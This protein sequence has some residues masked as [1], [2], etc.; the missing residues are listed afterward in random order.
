MMKG[1]VGNGVKI[2]LASATK[3][4]P[5]PGQQ[6]NRKKKQQTRERPNFGLGKAVIFDVIHGDITLYGL[7]T[8]VLRL[9]EFQRTRHV[10]QLGMTQVQFPTGTHSRFVHGIGAAWLCQEWLRL[11][12]PK[13]LEP[14]GSVTNSSDESSEDYEEPG[15]P[16]TTSEDQDEEDDDDEDDNDDGETPPPLN[17]EWV[18]PL[19]ITAR[20][21]ELIVTAALCHDIGHLA[22]SHM[23]DYLNTPFKHEAFGC[24]LIDRMVSRHRLCIST[25]EVKFIHSLIRGNPN[26][27][28]LCEPWMASL[29]SGPLDVDRFDYI[30]RDLVM[31][32]VLSHNNK[33]LDC[34]PRLMRAARVCPT[35]R[36]LRFPRS[37]IPDIRRVIQLRQRVHT[38]IQQSPC[39]QGMNLLMLKYMEDNKARVDRL[40]HED[41][42]DDVLWTWVRED[43]SS[44]LAKA[45]RDGPEDWKGRQAIILLDVILKGGFDQILEIGKFEGKQSLMPDVVQ[46]TTLGALV[47]LEFQ[48]DILRMKTRYASREQR[49]QPEGPT[50][51]PQDPPTVIHV[52]KPKRA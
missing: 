12:F 51:G 38:I 19:G 41:L 46:K 26:E 16:L 24:L 25:A 49:R 30:Q 1:G 10:S 17:G 32:G 47:P 18:G 9:P 5:G 3:R 29:I 36:T 21:R 31:T 52:P 8:R 33:L 42:V 44:R 7:P 13:D 35:T 40:G 37:A 23:H 39:A 20:T 43:R 50:P 6:P 48:T 11:L 22:F 34:V 15:S 2:H 4:T 27:S 28:P 14:E 45:L